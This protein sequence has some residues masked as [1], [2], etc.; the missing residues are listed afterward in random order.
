M[1]NSILGLINLYFVCGICMCSYVCIWACRCIHYFVHTHICQRLIFS[2]LPCSSSFH[3]RRQELLLNL[4]LSPLLGFQ[5]YTVLGKREGWQR[6][7]PEGKILL[8]LCLQRPVP[9]FILKIA[10]EKEKKFIFQTLRKDKCLQN[11][12]NLASSLEVVLKRI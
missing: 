1:K 7:R 11:D 12:F 9:S 3:F 2:C 5:I 8:S 4:D 6:A 10:M